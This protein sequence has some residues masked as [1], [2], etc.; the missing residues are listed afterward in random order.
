MIEKLVSRIP[1]LRAVK[2]R[3]R[4]QEQ[5]LLS[6]VKWNGGI[7]EYWVEKSGNIVIPISDPTFHTLIYSF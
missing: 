7:M 4:A 6:G 5:G 2:E 1:I 3:I